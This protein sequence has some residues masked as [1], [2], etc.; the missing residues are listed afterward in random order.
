[1]SV[2]AS[3]AR[4]RR[5]GLVITSRSLSLI[6]TP[7]PSVPV[8]L[9]LRLRL[10]S[11]GGVHKPQPHRVVLGLVTRVMSEQLQQPQHIQYPSYCVV[12]WH[13]GLLHLQVQISTL[14]SHAGHLPGGVD[15]LNGSTLCCS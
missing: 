5:P 15:R 2:H 12:S 4:S 3:I 6:A 9:I 8:I 1:M 10:P 11:S 13:S 7:A 14:L